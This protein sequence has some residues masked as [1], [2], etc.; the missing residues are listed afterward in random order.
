MPSSRRPGNRSGP[1]R[2]LTRIRNRLWWSMRPYAAGRRTPARNCGPARSCRTRRPSPARPAVAGPRAGRP[3]PRSRAL[4]V[5][6]VD[7]RGGDARRGRARHP[8]PGAGRRARHARRSRVTPAPPD[9]PPPGA[10]CGDGVAAGDARYAC[11]A[12][13]R[14]SGASLGGASEEADQ[15]VAGA[16][17]L[18]SPCGARGRHVGRRHAAPR[19]PA[20]RGTGRA[21]V[22]GAGVPVSSSSRGPSCV[23]RAP[24]PT[25]GLQRRDHSSAGHRRVR[26]RHAAILRHRDGY[27]H[28]DGYR[29]CEW[30]LAL[31]WF[32]P[33]RWWLPSGGW[34][35]S[36]EWRLG[37]AS[38]SR[39]SRRGS[40]RRGG[41]AGRVATRSA[42]H[43]RVR[44]RHAAIL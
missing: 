38:L 30:S 16:A 29:H 10:V 11:A 20:G 3:A 25:V 23:T 31:G 17:P 24:R 22:R 2:T 4:R 39:L 35:R 7:P 19:S 26:V 34:P 18:G 32:L 40:A 14:L 37:W 13:G 36:G 27:L 43:R 44:V 12:G 15:G 9:A 6:D 1:R 33:L 41:P 8:P 28:C 5:R 42:D 21:G